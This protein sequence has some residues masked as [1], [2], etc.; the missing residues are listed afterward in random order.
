M[1]CRR[2]AHAGAFGDFVYAEGEYL[3][4]VDSSCNLLHYLAK[5]IITTCNTSLSRFN[6]LSTYLRFRFCNLGKI[7]ALP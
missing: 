3:H 7:L 4:D 1:Y 2:Q 6:T 5:F